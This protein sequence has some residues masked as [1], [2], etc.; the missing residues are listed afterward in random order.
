MK[1][2]I[3]QMILSAFL[4]FSFNGNTQRYFTNY[5][6]LDGLDDFNNYS[7]VVSDING[8]LWLLGNNGLTKFNGT[9]FFN[10]PNVP[11]QSNSNLGDKHL[12][13]DV[14]GNIYM[15]TLNGLLKFDG[16]SSTL[17][18]LTFGIGNRII[19]IKCDNIGNVWVGTHD[20][21]TKFNG[22]TFTNYSISN[23]YVKS[24][25]I[26]NNGN[27]WFSAHDKG[28][29]KFNGTSYTSYLTANGFL[30]NQINSITCDAVGNI[31]CASEH[32]LSKF[33]GSTFT[34]YTVPGLISSNIKSIMC[35]SDGNIWFGYDNNGLTKYNGTNFITYTSSNDFYGYAISM[36]EDL[37]H[38]KWFLDH[39][40]LSL[41]CENFPSKPTIQS[42][43][44]NLCLV[45][46]V[47][48]T[49]SN[50]LR[51]LWSDGAK[52]QTIKTKEKFSPIS[53]KVYDS[54]GC[55]TTSDEL[56]LYNYK[57]NPTINIT[58]IGNLS[59]CNTTSDVTLNSSPPGLSYLWNTSETTQ[60]IQYNFTDM[61]SHSYSVT[62][63]YFNN[64]ISH[65]PSFT[66]TP[67]Q[68]TTPSL[69]LV[70]NHNNKNLVIWE[71][72]INLKAT[73]YRI[74]KQNK[75]TSN[76]DLIHEQNV[77]DLSEFLDTISTPDTQIDRYK[78]SIIDTCLNESSLSANHTTIL[79][80]S[81]IGTNNN[82]NLIWNAYDGFAYNNFE[83][84]RSLDGI[85]YNL[86]S[87][88]A[89]NTYSYIDNNPNTNSYYQIR[90][91][92]PAGCNSSKSIFPNVASNI[93]DKN[94][95]GVSGLE[96]NPKFDRINIY[97]NPT[98]DKVFFNGLND[99]NIVQ[100]FDINGKLQISKILNSNEMNLKEYLDK[101]FYF[102]KVTDSNNRVLINSSVVLL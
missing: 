36:T 57:I 99:G 63:H 86:L 10:Y 96:I 72:D 84:W 25:S 46:S 26:D 69:C 78:I 52:S 2:Y 94:G 7:D 73:K 65:S 14:Y 85:N 101:G 102:L 76:Y 89:N 28:L 91:T 50:G 47:Q 83:I 1:N 34:N 82:I 95:N 56:I 23:T 39:N 38:R 11:Y 92:N 9:S 66:L 55:S 62:I 60:N 59:F 75:I 53:V 41:Y 18:P 12:A 3:K 70:T 42:D 49:S 30:G 40:V 45:D 22:A 44:L 43:T 67:I 19:C 80:T 54:Y 37:Q 15:A 71:K 74:Y 33:N 5:S 35:D 87:T 90:I 8:D 16:V 20:G 98:L 97:P 51:Y 27:V 48:L 32:G 77:N 29:N 100:V 81:S 13:I 68:P 17:Y 58:T 79:L 88:V 4:L 24:I 31:W 64:C 93:I 21:L 6:T 61:N